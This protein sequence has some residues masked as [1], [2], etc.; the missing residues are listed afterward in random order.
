[1]E[2]L[3]RR[4]EILYL[5]RL[6]KLEQRVT[7][8]EKKIAIIESRKRVLATMSD[9][10]IKHLKSLVGQSIEQSGLNGLL[11]LNLDS[12]D[13]L[14]D[15]LDTDFIHDSHFNLNRRLSQFRSLIIGYAKRI[16]AGLRQQL[17]K[18]LS[19]ELEQDLLWVLAGIWFVWRRSG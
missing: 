4:I 5:A 14:F 1:M 6:Q 7:G 10:H 16:V 18:S 2:Q 19:E 15:T 12:Q 9:Q 8:T 13:P 3:I 17:N 11:K